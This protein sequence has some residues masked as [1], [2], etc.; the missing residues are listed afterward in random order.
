MQPLLWKKFFA[1]V[2]IVMTIPCI[3]RHSHGV[4]VLW[5]LPGLDVAL[6]KSKSLECSRNLRAL[7]AAGRFWNSEHGR[8]P[9]NFQQ[10]TNELSSPAL[11]YCPADLRDHPITNWNDVSWENVDYVWT[12]PSSADPAEIVCACRIHTSTASADG[13]TSQ[14][15]ERPG[16]SYFVAGAGIEYVTPGSNARFEVRIAPDATLPVHF[17]WRREDLFYQTNINFIA[18]PESAAGGS[19]QTNT[20]AK[21]NVTALPGQTNSFL[22]FQNVQTN[23]SAFYTV[24]ASNALGRSLSARAR[25]TVSPDVLT[26]TNET[27]SQRICL[28]NLRQIALLAN[29]W[30]QEHS[31]RKPRGF[32]EMTNR[33]GS[34]IF[35]WPLVLFCRSDTSRTA[36]ADWSDFNF[37]NTS[38]ETVPADEQNPYAIFC[39]CKV[40][41]FYA[42]MNGR[43][44]SRPSFDNTLLTNNAVELVLD[45][46]AGRTN[47]LESSTNFTSWT[48][49][50]TFSDTNGPVPFRPSNIEPH[51]F[52]RLRLE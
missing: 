30:A 5:P 12:P 46:F 33:F 52:Y 23:D 20:T 4:T 17:Q 34:P 9:T 51:L 25:L 10:F 31:E 40:H 45:L 27:W 43:A 29:L 3:T 50:T 11:L 6:Q 7:S 37:E 32:A 22:L 39:R 35:G 48:T 19:W 2:A 15:A 1:V 44:V 16:W 14:G 8:F 47:I 38:Y 26:M 24:V 41:G 13:S 28:N 18:D 21:F 42:E 49:V 36:P